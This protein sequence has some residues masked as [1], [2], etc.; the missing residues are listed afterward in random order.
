MAEAV[1]FGGLLGVGAGRMLE[2]RALHWSWAALVLALVVLARPILGSAFPV[3][4]AGALCATLAA[5]RRRRRSLRD[6]SRTRAPGGA[7]SPLDGAPNP[8]RRR[9]PPRR[10]PWD[11]GRSG[12]CPACRPGT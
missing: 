9:L 2:H 8:L 7:V 11:R 3:L 10:G 1:L 12:W 4:A 6:G 5:G